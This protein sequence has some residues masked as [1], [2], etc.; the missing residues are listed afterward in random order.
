M[1]TKI[2][3][4]F[5]FLTPAKITPIVRVLA[6]RDDGFHE[7]RLALVPVAL[8]D[9][10]SW[11]PGGTGL[12]L[13]V[14]SREPLGPTEDNL[15]YRAA[16][17]Y[18]SAT[19]R[20]LRGR[21]HLTKRVPTGAGLG[22]G[23]ANAAGTLAVLNRLDGGP[24]PEQRLWQLAQELGSDVPFFLQPHPQWAEGRGERLHPI[25]GFPTLP[26]LVI[27]P[28]FSIATA[29]AYR[30]VRPRPDPLPG[31][32]P[33][34]ALDTL[35]AVVAALVNDFE[36]ALF[37]AHPALSPIKERLLAAGARGALLSGSGSA[38]FGLFAD[39]PARDR[40]AAALAQAEPAWTVL[41]CDT[42]ERHAYP[43]TAL[44]ATK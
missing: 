9:S 21:L 25:A 35:A 18:Q 11:W 22:G 1:G 43:L 5:R 40:A 41:P 16:L 8:H 42:L 19:G 27:K 39:A 12:E 13:Q 44:E 37:P 2:Q 24:L 20:P 17:A 14:E 34:P 23:S 30:A 15:V 4:A 33:Y 32:P 10:I 28:P 3:G 26:V 38:I 7:V 31:A 6:R 36:P 29:Q